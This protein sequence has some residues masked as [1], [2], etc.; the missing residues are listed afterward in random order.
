MH[1]RKSWHSK[2]KS[3][4]YQYSPV[5]EW[6]E[7][8]TVWFICAECVNEPTVL[9]WYSCSR[10]EGSAQTS[11]RLM[12]RAQLQGSN[13]VCFSLSSAINCCQCV[14][15]KDECCSTFPGRCLISLLMHARAPHVMSIMMSMNP[16]CSDDS[17]APGQ[18]VDQIPQVCT[19]F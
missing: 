6:N 19:E 5:H 12:H 18:S 3:K 4:F 17:L 7:S 1:V 10:L 11:F 8:S 9:S 16:K 15:I 14:N 13:H 2:W